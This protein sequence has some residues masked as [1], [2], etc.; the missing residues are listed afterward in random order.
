[1][2]RVSDAMILYDDADCSTWARAVVYA[3]IPVI[4]M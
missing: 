1:M 4:L 3:E 2:K